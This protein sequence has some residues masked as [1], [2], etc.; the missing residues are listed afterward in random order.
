MNNDIPVAMA[1]LL[2]KALTVGAET[3]IA[4]IARSIGSSEMDPL[5]AVQAVVHMI[6]AWGLELSPNQARGTFESTRVLRVPEVSTSSEAVTKLITAGEGPGVEFKS[7]LL[8]SLRDWHLDGSLKEHAALPGEVL[9]TICAFLNSDGGELLIGVNDEGELS[10]GIE[11]D[12]DLKSWDLDKWQL[13]LI[14]LIEGRFMDGA[15]VMPY[16][17]LQLHRLDNASIAHFTVMQRTA[18]SFVRREKSKSYEFFVRNGSRSDS[19]ELPAFYAH[20][21]SRRE[22]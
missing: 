20:L 3:S 16:V 12:L 1:P 17:R 11:R 14:S 9:K 18:R 15:M 13:H 21:Q 7:S 19:L 10:G 2:A 8:C 6:E 22:I 5:T 4:E